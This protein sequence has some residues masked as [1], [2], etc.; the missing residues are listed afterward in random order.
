M[1]IVLAQTKG[2]VGKST[3][4]I[5]LAIERSRTGSDVLLIDADEQA[6]AT[7]FTALRTERLGTP[8][9]TA[10]A[11]TGAAVR[12]QVLRLAPKYQDIIIDAGGRD[13][14]SLRAALTVSDTAL[15][16]FQPR[17]FDLWT[18]EKIIS[19]LTEAKEYRDAPLR[20]LSLLNCAD[21][22]GADNAQAAEALSGTPDLRYLPTPIGRRKAFPNA[23]AA[24]RGVTE[25][26]PED[27]KATAEIGALTSALFIN[28]AAISE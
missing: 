22:Q 4:A 12:T 9:Y 24:G 21:P 13:T 16:P 20:A 23:A 11:L 28:A 18:L 2:G 26:K 15:V 19:L 10:I 25:L 3:L 17:S 6:T 1:I 7:D 27:P 14:A 5:N 8:G